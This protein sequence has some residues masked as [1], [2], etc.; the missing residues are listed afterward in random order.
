MLGRAPEDDNGH[1]DG[2]RW[3][4]KSRAVEFDSSRARYGV[5]RWDAAISCKD[6]HP[7]SITGSSTMPVS[8]GLGHYLVCS[9]FGFDFRHGLYT[10]LAEGLG[11]RLPSGTR[12]FESRS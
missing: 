5:V 12:A 10:S 1:A 2:R 8:N 3:D 6:A 11:I 7:V 4:S 9:A